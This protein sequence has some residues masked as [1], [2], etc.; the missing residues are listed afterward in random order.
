MSGSVLQTTFCGQQ[1]GGRKY[2]V[3][4]M[5]SIRVPTH[6]FGLLKALGLAELTLVLEVVIH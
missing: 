4:T 6:K 1:I 3:V 5:S 2:R